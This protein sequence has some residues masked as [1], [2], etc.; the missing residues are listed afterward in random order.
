MQEVLNHVIGRSLQSRHGDKDAT[1]W[2]DSMTA[3]GPEVVFADIKR[4]VI[5]A[6]TYNDTNIAISH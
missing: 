6:S 1:Q 5:D 3:V 4:H 2:L